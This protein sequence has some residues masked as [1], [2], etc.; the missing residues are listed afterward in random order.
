MYVLF[1]FSFS[2]YVE[3]LIFSEYS[4]Y[5]VKIL[6]NETWKTRIEFKYLN[7]DV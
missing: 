7:Y 3:S 6:H 1:E 4:V 2:K 5:I